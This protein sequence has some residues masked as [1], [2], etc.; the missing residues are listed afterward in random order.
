MIP[1]CIGLSGWVDDERA[2]L[3]ID[4]DL[5]HPGIPA[6]P[7]S[8]AG[9]FGAGLRTAD[10]WGAATWRCPTVPSLSDVDEDGSCLALAERVDGTDLDPC[11]RWLRLQGGPLSELWSSHTAR[12][13]ATV[14]MEMR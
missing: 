2:E 12:A 11:D 10:R 3:A 1:T 14:V 13:P 8:G 6:K 4:L 7:S 5:W 9:S